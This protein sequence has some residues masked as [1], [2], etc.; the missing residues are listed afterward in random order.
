MADGALLDRDAERARLDEAWKAARRGEPQLAIVWGRR[1][2][3]KTFLL[4]DFARPRRAVFFGATQ[5]SEGVELRRLGE[6]V[7]RDLGDR[8]ADLAGGSFASWEAALRYFAALAREKPLLVV[9]DEVPY[10]MGSTPGFASMVQVVWDHAA[11]GSKLML[12][13]TGSSIGVVATML[14]ESGA[15]HG[16]PTLAMRLDPVDILASRL[17]MGRLAPDRYLEAYA[18]CGGYPLHLK[19]WDARAGLRENLRRL[20]ASPDGLLLSDAASILAEELRGAGGH[21]RVLAA[22]GRGHTRYGE[23]A[24]EAGQRIEAPLETLIR[25]GFLRKALPVGAP[26]DAKPGYEIG[27]TYLAFWFSCL[28]AHQTEIE[29]G[30]GDAVLER[31][32]PSWQRHL[33]WV[34]EEAARA[35]AVRLVRRGD[36]P[37]DLVIGRWWASRGSPCEIDVLGLRGARVAL[38]G[39]AKWQ[40]SPLDLADLED[41]RRRAERVPSKVDSPIFALWGRGGVAARAKRAGALGWGLREML[42]E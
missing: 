29:A 34:F 36:L 13:L 30:Q 41:L 9:L 32:T 16:R 2:V 40:R 28:F 25:A 3:G 5:E 18:A 19:A 31:I 15:L 26:K 10:L 42:A 4:A 20:A 23:I 17:F 6:A 14:G 35:H 1:R 38:L 39:E 22:V 24:N 7:R 12:V 11:R 8:E 37:S 27:D 21:A 33:G